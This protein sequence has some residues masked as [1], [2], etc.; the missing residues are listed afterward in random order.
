MNRKWIGLENGDQLDE[1][2]VPRLKK[3][4]DGEDDG[5]ITKTVDWK[6]GGGF[7]YYEMY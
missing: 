7:R 5:G 4:I 3:V 1:I 2:C 6:G